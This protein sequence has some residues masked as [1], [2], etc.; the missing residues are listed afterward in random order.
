MS[1]LHAFINS[2]WPVIYFYLS[3]NGLITLFAMRS[4]NIAIQQS[5]LIIW[6]AWLI[7]T[8]LYVTGDFHL[9]PTGVVVDLIAALAFATLSGAYWAHRALA[10]SYLASAIV[11][12]LSINGAFSHYAASVV[13]NRF[14]E[15][16]LIFILV[17]SIR[18]HRRLRATKIA[19][20]VATARI[21]DERSRLSF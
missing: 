18:S 12:T 14:Y 21:F 10:M 17:W 6:A 3:V 2:E 19:P 1:V 4:Q 11:C 13:N 16:G 9:Y 20:S 5:I 15:A 8:F 7:M